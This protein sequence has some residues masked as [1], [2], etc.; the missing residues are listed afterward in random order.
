[1]SCCVALNICTTVL[2]LAKDFPC[3]LMYHT[4]KSRNKKTLEYETWKSSSVSINRWFDLRPITLADRHSKS[5][6]YKRE[7]HKSRHKTWLTCRTECR[8]LFRGSGARLTNKITN[9]GQ[10]WPGSSRC[11]RIICRHQRL[12][13]LSCQWLLLCREVAAAA[14]GGR[15]HKIARCRHWIPTVRFWYRRGRRLEW[16]RSRRE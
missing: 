5:S 10:K 11:S 15:R 3:H 8:V 12:W 16:R 2:R 13:R 9:A 1:M 4:S 6:L 7:W 14:T